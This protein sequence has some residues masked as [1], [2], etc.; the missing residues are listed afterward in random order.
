MSNAIIL[1]GSG[2]GSTI[3]GRSNVLR[4]QK[5]EE[6]KKGEFITFGYYSEVDV[7]S[8]YDENGKDGEIYDNNLTS[9]LCM[10]ENIRIRAMIENVECFANKNQW[11]YD[12]NSNTYY[13]DILRRYCPN[14]SGG[15]PKTMSITLHLLINNSEVAVE[16]IE[17]DYWVGVPRLYKMSN[18]RFLLSYY[19]VK[20]AEVYCLEFAVFEIDMPNKIK[21]VSNACQVVIANQ[22]STIPDYNWD[23]RIIRSYPAWY[24][25]D[26]TPNP[27]Y[28]Y[29][30]TR[31]TDRYDISIINDSSFYLWYGA[32]DGDK[33]I[34]NKYSCADLSEKYTFS[35]GIL[36]CVSSKVSSNSG[37][38]SGST[39]IY[40]HFDIG[41]FKH[42]T[43]N[44]SLQQEYAGK[45]NG[46]EYWLNYL[47]FGKDALVQSDDHPKVL[48]SK[49][50]TEDGPWKTN[51]ALGDRIW[52]PMQ[53]KSSAS[54]FYSTKKGAAAVCYIE[55]YF[56]VH[57]ALS[58]HY[59]TFTDP[60]NNYELRN[61]VLHITLT[62]YNEVTKESKIE[63]VA[64]PQTATNCMQDNTSDA[65]KIVI[66]RVS[67]DL[68]MLVENAMTGTRNARISFIRLKYN[69]NNSTNRW[70]FESTEGGIFVSAL[71]SPPSYGGGRIEEITR[72]VLKPEEAESFRTNE[73]N[74]FVCE[75]VLT[76]KDNLNSERMF[77]YVYRIIVVDSVTGKEIEFLLED[78]YPYSIERPTWEHSYKEIV[79]RSAGTDKSIMGVSLQNAKSLQAARIKE[80][81]DGDSDEDGY[82]LHLSGVQYT[83]TN[84]PQIFKTAYAEAKARKLFGK[85]LTEYIQN[86]CNF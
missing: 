13:N 43:E 45:L 46:T 70:Q 2:G 79:I 21:K 66:K 47:Y 29:G 40:S 73:S 83:E 7:K 42:I 11:R 17:K 4:V 22:H 52:S 3:N 49:R 71:M 28:D 6:V 12:I 9:Y 54:S 68:F 20:L 25:E 81:Y 59:G 51:S 39:N 57:Y 76:Y 63:I 24:Y 75:K 64:A 60:G 41:R 65:G 48:I 36:S 19:A 62:Q 34:D 86:K 31:S 5:G 32:Y 50:S 33:L 78:K 16:T 61:D 77:Y 38:K 1:G 8:R 10:N 67:R 58:A 72:N 55:K 37:L 27:V 18:N 56:N 84:A 69:P 14:F 30:Y 26:S 35:G 80:A 85:D 23:V 53:F 15:D 44:V 82:K 74:I